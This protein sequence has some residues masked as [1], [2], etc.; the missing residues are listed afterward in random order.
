MQLRH[1][2]TDRMTGM[3]IFDLSNIPRMTANL[4]Q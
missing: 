3:Q 4:L 1:Q 2:I